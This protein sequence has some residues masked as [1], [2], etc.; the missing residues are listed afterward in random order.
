M[1]TQNGYTC[2]K[3]DTMENRIE[4]IIISNGLTS[5]SFA[6]QIGVN[7][8]TISHILTGRNKPSIDVLQKILKRFTDVSADWLL[9]GNGSMND[10]SAPIGE[11]NT[12]KEVQEKAKTVEKVVI[13]YSDHTFQECK[14]S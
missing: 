4:K 1:V 14:P 8:S 5:N 12:V 9:L 3:H 7:R 6:Q 11:S 2:N 13:F 10:K